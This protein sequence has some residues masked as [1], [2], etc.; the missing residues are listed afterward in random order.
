MRT[1]FNNTTRASGNDRLEISEMCTLRLQE[2][3][4]DVLLGNSLSRLQERFCDVLLGDSV[5]DCLF[6]NIFGT[7]ICSCC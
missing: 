4:C 1:L 2:R 7:V 3:F 5:C 6:C